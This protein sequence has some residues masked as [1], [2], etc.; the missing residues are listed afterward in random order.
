[1]RKDLSSGYIFTGSFFETCYYREERVLL[2]EKNGLF[3]LLNKING[4][5]YSLNKIGFFIW[6]Q[7]QY[8]NI[9][10]IIDELR[11]ISNNNKELLFRVSLFLTDMTNF[12]LVYTKEESD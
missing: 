12:K 8:K 7:C 1:M 11:F 10:R 9:N 2:Q 4:Q 5:E 3:I 6:R